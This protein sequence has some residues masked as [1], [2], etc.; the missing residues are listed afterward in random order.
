MLRAE[1]DREGRSC[2]G[3]AIGRWNSTWSLENRRLRYREMTGLE[4]L[5]APRAAGAAVSKVQRV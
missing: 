2:Q 4:A 3:R 5:Q 1:L